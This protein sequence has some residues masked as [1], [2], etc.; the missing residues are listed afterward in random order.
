MQVRPP[1]PTG[2]T[3]LAVLAIIAGIFLLLG[4][5]GAVGL[6]ALGVASS[7]GIY[8]SVFLA[9]G[10]VVLILGILYIAIG[11][12]FFGGRGWS[13]T[14]GIIV[15]I[16][17]LIFD[18]VQ[19]G[20]A[21]VGGAGA[22]AAAIGGSIIPII[23]SLAILYYL[24]RPHVKAFFGK[25]PMMATPMTTPTYPSPGVPGP[26]GYSTSSGTMGSTMGTSTGNM[27]RCPSCGTSVA[28]GTTRCPN[29]G[30]NL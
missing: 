30:A 12:G 19:I 24:T 4:G 16:I 23:I 10:A 6:G 29:C 21:S 2:V 11:A 5:L 3:I 13:W 17:S 27:V 22:L 18:F 28:A 1:R 9:I 8:S 26:T 20:L 25:G 14:L 15:S 7:S